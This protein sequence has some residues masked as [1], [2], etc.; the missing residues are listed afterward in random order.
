MSRRQ[1][2]P[3][4][5]VTEFQM[6]RRQRPRGAKYLGFDAAGVRLHR[7]YRDAA[8]AL[9]AKPLLVGCLVPG[10]QRM[11]RSERRAEKRS[12]RRITVLRDA[13]LELRRQAQPGFAQLFW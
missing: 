6:L 12:Y 8:R 2:P 9:C 13:H 5:A 10:L 11:A 7:D 3:S 1:V 4:T